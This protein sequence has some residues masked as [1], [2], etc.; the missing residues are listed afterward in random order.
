MYISTLLSNP[1]FTTI[2]G[3]VVGAIL[4]Y[5]L[6][7]RAQKKQYSFQHK[8]KRFEDVYFLLSS[9]LEEFI[10][11]KVAYRGSVNISNESMHVDAFKSFLFDFRMLLIKNSTYMNSLGAIACSKEIYSKLQAEILGV[12]NKIDPYE[13][14]DNALQIANELD[15]I[16]KTYFKLINDLE[17]RLFLMYGK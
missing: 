3:V 11:F 15:N 7:I 9:E 6:T 2:I 16:D 17:E 5:F 8:L 10:K 14:P 12:L 13:Y 4:S 1:A